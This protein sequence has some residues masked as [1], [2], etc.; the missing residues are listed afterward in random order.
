M[1]K[2]H[3]AKKT[4]GKFYVPMSRLLV[5]IFLIFG[6][7]LST[8]CSDDN[9]DPKDET[10]SQND[11]PSGTINGYEWVDLGLPSG[12][13]WATCNVG[14]FTPEEYGAYFAWG[15][16]GTKS[17]YTEDNSI[18]YGKSMSDISGNAEY[19][20]ATA[21]WGGTWR[22]PTSTE[23]EELINNCIWAW[24]SQNGVDGY[25]VIGKNGNY[26]FLPAAGCRSGSSLI[27]AGSDGTY[28]SS[29]PQRTSGAYGLGLDSGDYSMNGY[30]R[31]YGRSVRPVSGAMQNETPEQPSTPTTTGSVNGFDWIDI[32]LPSGL[33]WATCN[34]GATKPEDY[35]NYY[36]W[37]ETTTKST[38]TS[39]NSTTFGVS[40]SDISGNAEYDAA[41]ANW[42][43]TWRMPTS[44]EIGELINNCTWA[45]TTQNEVNGYKVTGPNGNSIF[46]PAAGYRDGSSLYNAGSSGYYWSSTPRESGTYDAYYLLFNSSNYFGSYYFHYYGQSVRPVTE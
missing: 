7:T 26:I 42:G 43:G 35:G 20:A 15:E 27:S 45:W 17:S 38:Y 29:T 3:N 24:T 2:N 44:T 30:Y 10:N 37:G 36:A 31:Y 33:K 25:K 1:D 40:M 28:W 22:M 32:G 11:K 19:D 23:V 41:T 9:D 5:S 46:L 18:T 39:S 34:I 8:G 13:K 21:N 6:M 14:A 12:L 16:T 4:F